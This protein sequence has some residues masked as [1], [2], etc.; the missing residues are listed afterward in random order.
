[1]ASCV[2]YL[3]L[4]RT[5]VEQLIAFAH[6]P[7]NFEVR[8]ANTMPWGYNRH[9]LGPI[10]S[11]LSSDLPPGTSKTELLRELGST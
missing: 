8:E 9:D 7:R 10:R 3:A 4:H 5:A 2:T 1:M 11:I 6:L